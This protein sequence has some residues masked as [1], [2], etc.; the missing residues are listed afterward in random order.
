MIFELMHR[1]SPVA[2][3]EIQDDS[4]ALL[5]IIDVTDM[6][7]MPVGTVVDGEIR[8]RRAIEWWSSRAI[9]VSRSGIGRVLEALDIGHT[10]E[11][12]ARAMGLSLSDQYWIRKQGSETAWDDVNFFDNPFSDDV[13]DLLFG[14]KVWAGSMD[15]A[16]PDS[17]SDGV[18]MKRWRIIGDRR[19]LVKSGTRPFQQEPFNEVV[20][21]CIAESLGMDHVDYSVTDYCG[22]PCSVCEDF[23][24]KDT[25]FVPAHAVVRS[26][27]HEPGV[28][29]YDHYVSICSDNG[30]D[31]VPMLD[32]MM[33]LDYLMANGDRHLNNFGI[34]RD[35][36]TLRWLGPAPLF[37]TGTS[38]GHDSETD[39]IR[40][41]GRVGCKP[42]SDIWSA[43]MGLVSDTSWLDVEA[44]GK[45]IGR[46]SELL[47]S[48][49]RYRRNG[50]ADEIEAF[51]RKRLLDVEDWAAHRRA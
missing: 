3:L 13:G 49:E 20:A 34:I 33:V 45:A 18:L 38:L 44:V 21:S 19:C 36:R 51:L 40:D 14:R 15:F 37:D 17:A 32:R 9:P 35:S 50:R 47:H 24:T 31:V 7:R 12:L 48:V 2:T 39:D 6:G 22:M 23:V 46:S 41:C 16:S 11:L 29:L 4:G 43:Q 26:R 27:I 1:D 5:D 10:E 42:F 30:I 28:S 8:R 25:D